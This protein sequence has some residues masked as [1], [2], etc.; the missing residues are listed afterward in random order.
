MLQEYRNKKLLEEFIY[1]SSVDMLLTWGRTHLVAP[2]DIETLQQMEILWGGLGQA[3]TLSEDLAAG[4]AA[5]SENADEALKF[6]ELHPYIDKDSQAAAEVATA[7]ELL[8]HVVFLAEAIDAFPTRTTFPVGFCRGVTQLLET[9]TVYK[10]PSA[11]RLIPINHWRREMAALIPEEH[12]YLFP[13]YGHWNDVPPETLALLIDHRQDVTDDTLEDL[14]IDPAVLEPLLIDLA[15]DRDLL[16][17]IR[18]HARM[19]ELIPKAIES[20]LTLRLFITSEKEAANYAVP[21]SVETRGLGACAL[22]LIENRL[23]K[24]ATQADNLESMFMAAFCAPFL[25][26]QTRIAIFSRIENDLYRMDRASLQPGGIL[27]KLMDW[28]NGK[29]LSGKELAKEAFNRWLDDLAE[30]ASVAPLANDGDVA[31]TIQAVANSMLD[32]RPP[33]ERYS[34]AAADAQ[35]ER[36]WDRIAAFAFERLNMHAQPAMAQTLADTDNTEQVDAVAFTVETNNIIDLPLAYDRKDKLR[37]PG[38]HPENAALENIRGNLLRKARIYWNGVFKIAEDPAE[39]RL[40]GAP[41]LEKD[42]DTVLAKLDKAPYEYIVVCISPNA[43]L[44]EKAMTG[45][46][47]TDEEKQQILFLRYH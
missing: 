36:I 32:W 7:C 21:A 40:Y 45:K 43:D 42:G 4:L 27:A 15:D 23:K 25:T 22:R 37:I 38:H 14:D 2:E 3:E 5:L 6:F 9:V 11:L 18:R 26:D 28:A 44:I 46:E 12:R 35:R 31:E 47:L 29:R 24:R 17:H 41:K 33:I 8:D 13:W 30:I 16:A 39:K 34:T 19:E 10:V 1:S 20:S